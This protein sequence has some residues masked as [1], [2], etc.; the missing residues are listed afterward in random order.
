M[1]LRKIEIQ[2][3]KTF[4]DRFSLE[5][6]SYANITAI[7][8]PNGCGKSNFLEAVRW[9]IGEQSLKS[10]RSHSS[11]DIIFTGSKNRKPVSMAEV[12]IL[13]DNAG[14]KLPI[15]YN[16]V[17][18]KRKLYRSGESEYFIN[19][20][21]CK[22]RDINNL[23]F[24]TGVGK[25]SYSIIG[26]GQID[27][28]INMK[29]D[30]KRLMFEEAAGI[31][32][33][34]QRKQQAYRKLKITTENLQRIT[35][36][37]TEIH[38]QVAE[39]EKQAKEAEKYLSL[40]ELLK[41]KETYIYKS[42]IIS[43]Q[44]QL[45][46]LN[47]QIKNL[48][49]KIL[50]LSTQ[51]ENDDKQKLEYR[52]KISAL[53]NILQ[54]NKIKQGTITQNIESINQALLENMENTQ[55]EHNRLETLA[56]EL[57]KLEATLNM[58]QTQQQETKQEDIKNKEKLS[59]ANKQINLLETDLKNSKLESHNLQINK[60]EV[61][62]KIQIE[63]S[64]LNLLKEIQRNYEGYFSGVKAVLEARDE[65]I[66]SQ[67]IIGIVA[68]LIET[69]KRYEIALENA[70]GNHL[71]DIV[72]DTD[73]TAKKAINY[74]QNNKAGKATFLP[75]N[76]IRKGHNSSS[77]LLEVTKEQDGI[78]SLATSIVTYNP[79]YED[80][81]YHLLGNI[82]IAE[83]IDSAVIFVRSFRHLPFSRI[84]TLKGEIIHA[85]GAMTGGSS[86]KKT[87][88][89]LN[90][91]KQI[92]QAKENISSFNDKLSI[93]LQKEEVLLKQNEQ[94]ENKLLSL[95]I[96]SGTL[97]EYINQAQAK[98]IALET[99]KEEQK[100]QISHKKAEK[101]NITINIKNFK[102]NLAK[103]EQLIPSLKNDLQKLQQ[104]EKLT[105]EEKSNIQ[106]A[107]DNIDHQI[108]HSTTRNQILIENLRKEEIKQARLE[109]D[110]QGIKERLLN[111]YE[112]TIEAVL[113]IGT[114]S[115]QIDSEDI[116][117]LKKTI[118]KLEPVNLLA[119]EEYNKKSE[120][121]N[122]LNN[123][124]QDLVESREN[125]NKLIQELDHLAK[126]DFIKTISKIQI[127]FKE[128][129]SKLFNGGE[130]NIKLL[131]NNNVL[132]SGV[133]IFVNLP[134]KKNLEM[135]LLSGGEKALTAVALIFALL[136]TKPAPFCL[137]DEVDAALDEANIDKF[138]NML[139]SFSLDS[140]MIIITHN[141]QTL[142]AADTIYG[143]TMED[144]GVSKVISVK[145]RK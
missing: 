37:K 104:E 9:C 96:E 85:S 29:P 58:I 20:N 86:R 113:K 91:Q 57:G 63:T 83:N 127:N 60:N 70:L 36:L 93:I 54:Q 31:H 27:L 2:G 84:V 55:K 64:R 112:T 69:E 18:I 62:E 89:L 134:G 13:I 56:S 88:P 106:K 142:T 44:N 25:N 21:P 3:F 28:L 80:V 23:F 5:F 34:K 67:G 79:S 12:S 128:T 122:F 47:K 90:R 49:E 100:K 65:N 140:Q 19:K 144:P 74:L 35:D 108:K 51:N 32:K 145:L 43:L 101:D 66:L 135:S 14:R 4:A 30:E 98:T 107:I 87:I 40:K 105:I 129:F 45:T 116:K 131:E 46:E 121:Q 124:A 6:P 119:I 41:E 17:L 16:E 109:T 141:K 15:E 137:L 10:L 42:K 130:A 92:K 102:E 103:Q 24:D 133:E 22:L 95:K 38:Q 118:K 143:I 117:Q 50:S 78:I 125:L 7:V 115:D 136:K 110:L 75:I 111:D 77:E 97:E 138:S 26:Q 73:Q 8:G 81:I 132:E 68:N 114:T 11:S 53:E 139:A 94:L 82:I 52:N 72:T 126:R 61:R 120:K 48:Q 1:Y 123:Q 39:L 33:Y 71:Q 59:A 99:S 76:L